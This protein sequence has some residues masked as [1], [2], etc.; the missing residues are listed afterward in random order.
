MICTGKCTTV[1]LIG[2]LE[3]G[4]DK[5]ALKWKEALTPA[6]CS[7]V[8]KLKFACVCTQNYMW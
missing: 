1:A 5:K 8:V 2:S 3:N 7:N 6:Y 4:F